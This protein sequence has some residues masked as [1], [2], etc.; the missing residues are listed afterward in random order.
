MSI[1][2]PYSIRAFGIEL[3]V[4]WSKW[5]VG[6]SSIRGFDSERS[7]LRSPTRDFSPPESTD[8]GLYISSPENKKRA[9]YVSL[10]PSR[11]FELSFGVVDFLPYCTV[12]V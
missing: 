5:F 12:V 3:G 1:V 9:S 7:I 2:P 11:S 8:M 6:S 10:A 4:L